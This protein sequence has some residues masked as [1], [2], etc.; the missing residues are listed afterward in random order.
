MN[1]K[2]KCMLFEHKFSEKP[3]R[4]EV[5]W[6]QTNIKETDI[7]IEDLA[8][9][10]IQGASFKPAVLV[11]GNRAENWF[12]QQLFV[13]DFDGGTEIEE[14]YNNAVELG[15]KP[16][17]MYTT[18]SHTEKHHK[19]RMIFCSDKVIT[20]GNLRDKLQATLMGIMEGSDKVCFNRDRLFFGGRGPNVIHTDFDARINAKT[21]IDKYWDIEFKKYMPK[22]ISSITPSCKWFFD[23]FEHDR[24][25][26]LPMEP[27]FDRLVA[28]SDRFMQIG[29]RNGLRDDDFF[30]IATICDKL[31]LGG[32]KDEKTL[33]EDF[34]ENM[35]DLA[36][37][38]YDDAVNNG[39]SSVRE[40]LFLPH[41][42]YRSTPTGCLIAGSILELKE[43][44]M[45]GRFHPDE[46]KMKIHAQPVFEE[47]LN[48]AFEKINLGNPEIVSIGK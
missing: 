44:W 5:G 16:C 36:I 26:C 13:L 47:I 6:V 15:I 42:I 32:G 48:K 20:D 41:I 17:F 1:N 24:S 7:S 10:L 39:I 8:N 35:V 21:V 45:E 29:R 34:S 23:K 40:R 27:Q 9:E 43:D 22:P 31:A 28:F 18:F 25:Y 2:I 4:S 14:A 3:Q 46:E 33:K 38:L 37:A 11:G 12:Q 30:F 19:F